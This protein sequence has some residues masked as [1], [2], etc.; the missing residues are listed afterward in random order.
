MLCRGDLTGTKPGVSLVSSKQRMLHTWAPVLLTKQRPNE[1]K[2]ELAFGIIALED[3]SV[4]GEKVLVIYEGPSLDLDCLTSSRSFLM[5]LITQ[6]LIATSD[7]LC[8]SVGHRRDM[9][10]SLVLSVL[11]SHYT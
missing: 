11:G 10:P 5:I 2:L 4:C 6:W 3:V 9:W 1:W 8:W 7:A